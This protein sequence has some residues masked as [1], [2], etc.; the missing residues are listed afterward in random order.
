MLLAVV[1]MLLDAYR[2]LVGFL[3]PSLLVVSVDAIFDGL[4][5]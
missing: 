3:D 1:L 4:A 5:V 2:R